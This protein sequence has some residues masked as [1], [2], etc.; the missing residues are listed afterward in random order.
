M[1]QR[2]QSNPGLCDGCAVP[3]SQLRSVNRD[4]KDACR[5]DE[6]YCDRCWPRVA[7]Q[8]RQRGQTLTRTFVGV[9]YGMEQR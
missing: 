3:T 8:A 5:R 6:W 1:Q 4:L 2:I 9:V 7:E